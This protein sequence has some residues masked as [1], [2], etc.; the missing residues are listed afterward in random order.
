[1]SSSQI[2]SIRRR[3]DRAQR[4]VDGIAK[5]AQATSAE[6]DMI[7][8]ALDE[9]APMPIPTNEERK[10]NGKPLTERDV[11]RLINEVFGDRLPPYSAQNKRTRN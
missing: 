2:N 11:V 6:L 1:M 5:A 7:R 8:H 9:I 10:S 4:N 3:I